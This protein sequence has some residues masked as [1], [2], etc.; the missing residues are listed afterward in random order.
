MAGALDAATGGHQ[1]Q[2]AAAFD[3]LPRNPTPMRILAVCLA[4]LAATLPFQEE[5]PKLPEVGKPAPAFRLN[6]HEG[7]LAGVGGAHELWTV[8]AFYPKAATPG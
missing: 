7:T 2:E 6:T 3:P 4:A 1:D 8:V 5:G